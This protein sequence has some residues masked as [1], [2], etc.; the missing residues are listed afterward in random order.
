[1]LIY[2]TNLLFNSDLDLKLSTVSIDQTRFIVES[3]IGLP[4]IILGLLFGVPF[5]LLLS[6]ALRQQGIHI[7]T[8]LVFCPP[9]AILSLLFGMTKQKKS[10]ITSSG[11]AI[12]SF[13]LFNIQREMESPL[14]KNGT[15][16]TYKR[17]SSGGET[18]GCYFYH[19]EIQGLTGFGFSISK[20][21]VKRDE[22]AQELAGFLGYGI[23]EQLYYLNYS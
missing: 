12:K 13:Q 8:A 5:L 17:W 9:L 15:L 14:P 20:N 1:M 22:F 16:V 7:L 11:R 21:E 2:F 3:K 10:F 23:R 6:Y 18:G 4:R 19:V